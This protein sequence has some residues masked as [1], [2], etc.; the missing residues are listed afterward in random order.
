VICFGGLVLG[1]SELPTAAW[2]PGMLK[3]N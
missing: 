2:R 1:I 3:C